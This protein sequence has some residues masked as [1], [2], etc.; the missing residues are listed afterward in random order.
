[1]VTGGAGFVGSWTCER[2]LD[3]GVEV[4][5]V[6]NLATGAHS[7]VRHLEH[8]PGFTFV[9]QDVS[10]GLQVKGVVDWVLH[11]A[12]PASPVHYLRLPI[13]TLEVGSLGTQ[14]A[15][16]LAREKGAR[17]LLAST[18]EVY[19]D[20]L[21][22]PQRETYWG[23]V[24]PIGPRSV[25]DES[26][27]FAEAM[28]MAYR[29]EHHVDTAIA[30]I[31]NTFGPRMRVDDGRAIPAFMSQALSGRPLTVAGDGSQTRSLCYVED[32]VEGLL[33]LAAS[34]HPGP[35]NIGSS[36]ETTM[37]ELAERV[38]DLA[39]SRSP[40]QFVDLPADD[41]KKRQAD[42]TLAAEVLGWRPR[43]PVADGLK[44]TL[45]WF[46]TEGVSA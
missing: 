13:E 37:L 39:G 7:N 15:L 36:E 32:T 1:V 3:L 19:G 14:H 16:D 44:R 20:P 34:S 22:H 11:L 25:Y 21:E 26:K 5:C 18:S 42:T 40:V 31:F 30:R 8:R 4:V 45:E 10:A 9:E 41:P 43:T 33:A 17:F 38:R 28:T 29:N 24:N 35:V 46:A 27:R 2:L 23:N 6:D 12:S